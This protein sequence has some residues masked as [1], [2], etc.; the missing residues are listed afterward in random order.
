[1][2]IRKK[3]NDLAFKTG[4]KIHDGLG[5]VLT[6]EI[7]VKGVGM[8]ALGS[9]L[10]F[11]SPNYA[12]A[13]TPAQD[14]TKT[15]VTE[16]EPAAPKAKGRV[17]VMA[18]HEGTTIDN[19]L[20]MPIV[21]DLSTF[22]RLRPTIDDEGKMG[23]FGL[24]QLDYK[25]MGGLSVVADTWLNSAEKAPTYHS[26]L[27]YLGQ[28][29]F[30]ESGTL[31]EKAGKLTLVGVA[32]GTLDEEGI[33][34]GKLAAGYDLPLT[35]M[36]TLSGESENSIFVNYDGNSVVSTHLLRLGLGIDRFEFGAAVDMKNV[37]PKG[38]K[39]TF[40][41]NAGGYFEIKLPK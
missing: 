9:A 29:D 4:N 8:L 13:E 32:K 27:F 41:F 6:A 31:T 17:E 26:G 10:A 28:F 33:F 22:I 18:G 34:F 14:P 30:E 20:I 11:G 5:D 36:L 2:G 40:T 19:K 16:E 1:M 21:G 15:E 39:N 24:F 38:S 25:L 37:A 35:D 7:N 12:N 3:L 23:Y